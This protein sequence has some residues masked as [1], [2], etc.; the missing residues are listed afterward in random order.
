MTGGPAFSQ[1]LSPSQQACSPEPDPWF[2]SVSAVTR[3]ALS[4]SSQLCRENIPQFTAI[5]LSMC[6]HTH[7]HTRTRPGI[8]QAAQTDIIITS[9]IVRLKC[10]RSEKERL[11]RLRSEFVQAELQAAL[12]MLF[13]LFY[14]LHF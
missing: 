4:A 5:K 14:Y 1:A 7:T 12:S 9:F 10:D 2:V 11:R 6:K 3:P 13:I 8:Q